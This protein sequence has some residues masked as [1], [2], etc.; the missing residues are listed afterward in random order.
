MTT[1]NPLSDRDRAILEFESHAPRG[2]GRKEDAIRAQL[3]IS[4]VRYHQ[5]LNALL[6]VPAAMAAYPV[7]VKRLRR[8]REQRDDARR[9]AHH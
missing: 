7:L 1:S 6:D 8:V 2:Q 5:R 3:D 9:A 4:S